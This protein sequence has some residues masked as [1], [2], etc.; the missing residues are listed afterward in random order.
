MYN[1]RY[2]KAAGPP[3]GILEDWD[4]ALAEYHDILMANWLITIF[5][6][7]VLLV[8]IGCLFFAIQTFRRRISWG[9]AR[10]MGVP[11]AVFVWIQVLFYFALIDG[12]YNSAIVL[13]TPITSLTC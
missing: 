6:V 3:E 8:L 5:Y 4:M 10:V 7:V 9:Q 1:W 12:V 13:A 11:F 2:P